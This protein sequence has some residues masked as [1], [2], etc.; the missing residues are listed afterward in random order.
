MSHRHHEHGRGDARCFVRGIVA[1]NSLTDN[2]FDRQRFTEK[3]LLRPQMSENGEVADGR[4]EV[5]VSVTPV[6]SVP[7]SPQATATASWLRGSAGEGQAWG[8]GASLGPPEFHRVP[9]GRG[10]DGNAVCQAKSQVLRRWRDALDTW[11]LGIGNSA[12]R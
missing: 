1:S 6:D 3:H 2:S 4:T 11:S 9:R 8:I 10:D 7:D 12:G 5:R